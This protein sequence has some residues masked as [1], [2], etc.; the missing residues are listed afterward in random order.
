MDRLKTSPSFSDEELIAAI[1]SGGAKADSAIF[2]LYAKYNRDVR[3]WI[4]YLFNQQGI[5]EDDATDILHDSFLTALHKIQYEEVNVTSLKSYWL[6]I[7]K[8]GRAH[9]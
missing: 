8:I 2:S 3:S 9:V 6:G 1:K 4:C 5:R 7:A